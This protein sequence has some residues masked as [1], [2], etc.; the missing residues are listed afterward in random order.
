MTQVFTGAEQ[1]LAL[2]V[3]NLATTPIAVFELRDDD[4]N[5]LRFVAGN[6]RFAEIFDDSRLRSG[7]SI[8]RLLD[9]ITR[10][11]A[12]MSASDEPAS[13]VVPDEAGTGYLRIVLQMPE[14]D[15]SSGPR[16]IVAEFQRLDENESD[17]QDLRSQVR[18]LQ[19]LADNSTA[20]MYVKNP[21]GEYTIVNRYFASLFGRPASEILG[22]TDHDLFDAT[23]ADV[24]QEHD[25][26]VLE[27]E[28]AREVEEPFSQMGGETDPDAD[29]RWLSIK[30]PLLDDSGVPYALGAISTDITARKRAESAATQAM[31]EAERAN[32]SK[33]A[34]LSRMSHEL[35]TPLNAVLGFA[36]LLGE[37]ELA[38][39]H[40]QN[41]SY[42]LEAGQ[43]LLTLVNDVL[44]IS[45]LESGAPGITTEYLPASIPIHQALEIIRPLAKQHDIEIASDLHGAIDISLKADPKRLKQVF[46]NLLGNAIKFNR[47][48]GAIRVSTKQMDG[49]LR[50][51][52]TDTGN[53]IRP[54]EIDSL[55]APFERLS[56]AVGIEGSG[57]GLALS[58]AL[59]EE[60]G[61]RI[62]VLHTAPGEG[63][64]F[65]VDLPIADA[66]AAQVMPIAESDYEPGDERLLETARVVQ[67]EDTPA[68]LLLL[69][70]VL[71][72]MGVR[73][74]HNAASGSE[75]LDLIR[76]VRPHAVFLDLNLRDMSGAEVIA[77]LAKDGELRGIPI[78]ILSADATPARMADLRS[79]GAFAY[80]TKPFDMR[81]LK[82]TLVNAVQVRS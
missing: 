79:R 56:N 36:Q 21:R 42:I 80:L 51:L 75:G 8:P 47:P 17:W 32:R 78:I 48:H 27:S 68:N 49:T 9:S 44:D 1:G 63:T 3:L 40:R 66:D 81:L 24:Y 65:F 64:S 15:E 23:S 67:I 18:Q 16:R 76:R 11:V 10:V 34:F 59:V 61:G 62:G 46:F 29:R 58:R 19:D 28:T 14:R 12:R 13:V 50:Y 57:L 4:E 55:F 35:R 39:E 22:K 45:W 70:E 41:V 33:S 74:L 6:R 2:E 69:Q 7:R 77:E 72:R 52:I 5:R 38:P 25:R 37:S 71:T 82:S 43:H 54:E 30:F 53:G 26:T 31:H 60:M 20:L 73:D